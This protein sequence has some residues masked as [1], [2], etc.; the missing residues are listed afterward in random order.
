MKAIRFLTKQSPYNG[1]EVA[2]FSDEVADRYVKAGVAEYLQPGAPVAESQAP[3]DAGGSEGAKGGEGGEE[4]G[5]TDETGAED[6]PAH[7]PSRRRR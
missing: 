3:G 1:G 6:A 7:G 5:E 2:G 4:A